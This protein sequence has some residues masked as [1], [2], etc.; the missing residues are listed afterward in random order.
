MSS[1]GRGKVL[2]P[3][4]VPVTNSVSRINIG[5]ERLSGHD[6]IPKTVDFYLASISDR[7]V[8]FDLL[9]RSN[10]RS[11]MMLCPLAILACMLCQ[12]APLDVTKY[13]PIYSERGDHP[14]DAVHK[15]F[16][17]RTFTSGET[18]YHRLSFDV[19]WSG[20]RRLSTSDTEYGALLNQL[21][22]VNQL[23]RHEMEDASPVRRLV[24]YRDLW[25]IFE[26]LKHMASKERSEDLRRRLARIM[27]RLELKD[28]EIQLLPDT[29]AMVREK[30]AFPDLPD[31]QHPEKPFLPTTLLSNTSDWI[32]IST[33][34]KSAMGA[35][36]H[37]S[38]VNQRSLFSIHMNWPQGRKAGEEFLTANS[39]QSM[40]VFPP[41]TQLA[42][43]RRAVAANS[44]GKLKVTNVV[45]SLQ[46]LVTPPDK[47]R[48]D[49]RFK[50]VLDR[51]EFLAG[52]SVLVALEP[53]SPV[54]AYSFESS[55]QWSIRQQDDA[56][57]E[58]LVLGRGKGHVGVPSMQHCVACHGV[59][60]TR[61]HANFSQFSV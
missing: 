39:R 56:D 11:R 19:P 2:K 20:F 9:Q 35:P 7:N 44:H 60:N 46:L 48:H 13:A 49:A 27:K 54:D 42:L 38:S 33:S 5:A 41:G 31:P 6:S 50:F 30:S 37:S 32:S 15:S 51:S 23:P 26:A 21:T 34:K 28:D 16:F 3:A 52:K 47:S 57:G 53:D 24:F 45:E 61:F 36:G 22:A 43:L 25:S 58:L 55:G 1:I 8:K 14:W 10:Q 40:V 59:Q 29:L 17:V 4:V 12:S 18:Y